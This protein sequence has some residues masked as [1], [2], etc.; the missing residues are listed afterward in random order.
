[1]IAEITINAILKLDSSPTI[2]ITKLLQINFKEISMLIEERYDQSS[3]C[4]S[5]KYLPV[6]DGGVCV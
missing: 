6:A 4:M 3:V 2:D 1:M 5:G